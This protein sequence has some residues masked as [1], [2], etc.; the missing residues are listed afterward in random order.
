MTKNITIGIDDSLYNAGLDL[1]TSAEL[2]AVVEDVIRRRV[3]ES[4]ASSTY[5]ARRREL[6]NHPAFGMWK[7]RKDIGDGLEYQRKLRTEWE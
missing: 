4:P 6:L 7:G 2:R 5:E 1:I 3:Q